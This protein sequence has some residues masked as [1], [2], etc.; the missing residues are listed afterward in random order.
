MNIGLPWKYGLKADM[1]QM[2]EMYLIIFGK[3]EI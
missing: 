2:L 3:I 1:N